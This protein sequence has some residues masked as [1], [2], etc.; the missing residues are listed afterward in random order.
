MFGGTRRYYGDITE[1]ILV[2][3]N[4]YTEV[5]VSTAKLILVLHILYLFY[6]VYPGLTELILVLQNLY[7]SYGTYTGLTEIILVFQSTYLYF[8]SYTCITK[9]ILEFQILFICEGTRRYDK[10]EQIRLIQIH[11]RYGH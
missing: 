6:E 9:L 11:I 2:L 5:S 1:R 10:S 7:W 3:R 4:P 8:G